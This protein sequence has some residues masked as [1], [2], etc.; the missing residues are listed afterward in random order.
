VTGNPYKIGPQDLL[1]YWERFSSTCA[2]TS[3]GGWSRGRVKSSI[4]NHSPARF[5]WTIV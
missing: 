5:T 3:W 1:I 2:E 4:A